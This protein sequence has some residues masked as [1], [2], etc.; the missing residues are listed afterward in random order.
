MNDDASSPSE[1][2]PTKSPLKSPNAVDS[3]P[4][5]TRDN[6]DSDDVSMRSATER[7]AHAPDMF[8]RAAANHTSPPS[9]DH[10]SDHP[11][12]QADRP[13]DRT[14]DTPNTISP[15]ISPA[16]AADAATTAST[17]ASAAA[18][19][20][21]IL[22]AGVG[23]NIRSGRSAE[24]EEKLL[25]AANREIA[26]RRDR[27]YDPDRYS[28]SPSDQKDDSKLLSGKRKS[29]SNRAAEREA[30]YQRLR[31][32]AR[33]KRMMRGEP[34]MLSDILS[35]AEVDTNLPAVKR[36]RTND[37]SGS[38]SSSS[39]SGSD[40][41][42][43]DDKKG[44]GKKGKGESKENVALRAHRRRLAQ[45]NAVDEKQRQRIVPQ[46]S[47][48]DDMQTDDELVRQRELAEEN[49]EL[50]MRAASAAC[51]P[52]PPP[53]APPL[54]SSTM[55]TKHAM[56]DKP[57]EP[58]GTHMA[59]TIASAA[60]ATS[61]AAT[62]A[63]AL[64]ATLAGGVGGGVGG[65]KRVETE[66]ERNRRRS[67]APRALT[68]QEERE[69]GVW[70]KN[71]EVQQ[72]HDENKEF[73]VTQSQ[74]DVRT[75]TADQIAPILLR[76][77]AEDAT[78]MYLRSRLHLWLQIVRLAET[79]ICEGFQ[80]ADYLFFG[81]QTVPE[82]EE[83]HVALMTA[84]ERLRDLMNRRRML[85]IQEPSGRELSTQLEGI[86][87]NIDGFMAAKYLHF[88]LMKGQKLYLAN[89]VSKL[90]N[91]R[92]SQ[93]QLAQDLAAAKE[94]WSAFANLLDRILE[95]AQEWR[96]V[97]ID[98]QVHE[99]VM[100][101]DGIWT[102]CYKLWQ[103]GE[104]LEFVHRAASLKQKDP[105]IHGLLYDKGSYWKQI[106]D[107]L[108]HTYDDRFPDVKPSRYW[109]S[110]SNGIYNIKTDK[111]YEYKSLAFKH[112]PDDVISCA[113][114]EQ[115]FDNAEYEWHMEHGPDR[116]DRWYNIPTPNLD[117]ICNVQEWSIGE[118][119]WWFAGG[120][121]L[122]FPLGEL[123]NW[124]KMWIHLGR[125]GC[126]KTTFLKYIAG[127]FPRSKVGVINNNCEKVFTIQHL[128]KTWSWFGF[129]IKDDWAMDQTLWNTMIDGGMLPL[130][131]K[132][133]SAKLTD[134]LQ[135][136]AIASN[137]LMNWPDLNGQLIRRLFPHIY[138]KAPKDMGI[139]TLAKDMEVE[140]GAALKKFA[141]S[142]RAKAY[143]NRDAQL[144]MHNLPKS[145]VASLEL[146]RKEANP[147]MAFLESDKFVFDPNYYCDRRRFTQAFSAYA[148]EIGIRGGKK[149]PTVNDAFFADVL[150]LKQL[151]LAHDKRK[152]PY[153]K[154]FPNNA[155]DDRQ[156]INGMWIVG[157]A[158]K[159][160][161]EEQPSF[162]K[163]QEDMDTLD[164]AAA[165]AL[166]AALQ[167]NEASAS[168]QHHQTDPNAPR[169]SG[170]RPI[171]AQ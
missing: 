61:A 81:L 83:R 53:P 154:K 141:L 49:N 146:I 4:S 38:G 51:A 168:Q 69:K 22:V 11:S 99:P 160:H 39:S 8:S 128:E 43:D 77:I 71:W 127:Y 159:E 54:T 98:G 169:F 28:D 103:E 10:P 32:E 7:D 102:R 117:K 73:G 12:D 25:L 2:S 134:F 133:L 105:Q 89:K 84:S 50:E 15:T 42:D 108:K 59:A 126:G 106:V 155:T 144:S 5:K 70:K 170:N 26:K 167:S 17:S 113:H 87:N 121:R 19:A 130:A 115:K 166:E 41:D 137:R 93:Q 31:Q 129:D 156:E 139:P 46:Y 132:Y 114:F 151:R 85:D 124:G 135:H 157:C 165:N 92:S 152:S 147:L 62:V 109:Y 119:K 110:F 91:L 66:D 145:I 86:Q 162:T 111:F 79:N 9:S 123:D 33:Q 82:M 118:R 95:R 21:P 153:G 161:E 163:S 116:K 125:A 138:R 57:G 120:G 94:Q 60:S 96:L 112:L 122:L 18:S 148:I 149:L 74:I 55:D 48:P 27:E 164:I 143:E 158:F 14:E 37:S 52:P 65:G 90:A 150:E 16:A 171:L 6:S 56:Q 20:H 34:E 80:R 63:T 78:P 97:R 40:N 1:P 44:G 13:S 23:V 24:N 76:P 3:S 45:Q 30:S 100:T 58:R 29:K 75:L 36:K 72:R 136:G 67:S 88:D 140:R 131:R 142:Y 35:D 101:P 64:A 47:G 107:I 68:I 104:I